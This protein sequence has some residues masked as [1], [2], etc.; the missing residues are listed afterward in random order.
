[1]VTTTRTVRTQLSSQS[2]VE[3]FSA[4]V[5]GFPDGPA[6]VWRG[7]PVSYRELNDRALR[8]KAELSEADI[9]AA[10]IGVRCAKS[11]DSVALV[12]ACLMDQR[13]FLLPSTTLPE[14]TLQELFRRAGCTR[15]LTVSDSSSG[16]YSWAVVPGTDGTR[17]NHTRHNSGVRSFSPDPEA[18]TFMLT[19]SGSTGPPKIVPLSEGAVDRFT[20]WAGRQFELGAGRSVLNVSPLSFDLC[21]LDIWA[22]LKH[23]G[24]VV[25]VEP[26]QATSGEYLRDLLIRHEVELVQAVPMFYQLLTRVNRDDAGELSSVR[27]VV[28]TGDSIAPQCL[29][30]LPGMFPSA[31]LYNLYGCTET[32]DSLSY[33]IDPTDL[34]TSALPLGDPLP[35]VRALLVN[36][37]GTIRTGPGTGELYVST[38]FQTS[39]YLGLPDHESRFVAHPDGA[40]ALRYFRTGDLVHRHENGSLTLEG[41]TDFQVKV[42]GV[43]TNIEDVERVLRTHPDIAEVAVVAV[44]DLVAGHLL[45]AETRR[46]P[47][48]ALNSLLLRRFCADQLPLTAIPTTFRITDDPLPRTSTGKPDRHL[49]ARL[50]RT[51]G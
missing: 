18:V 9:G 47:G 28:V 33:E 19:T 36:E 15:V 31:R 50:R 3:S 14:H 16:R 12:L 35:G 45:H 39:G 40:D 21:L 1:M 23:G 4:N 34:P 17:H 26:S 25:L 30:Q 20:D 2:F 24:C 32:N 42:R 38:P 7:E 27:H 51:E 41:R 8:A 37:D 11:P 22:T 10:P 29:V 48:S 6:L 44:P 49:V 46:V 5:R 13:S 43:R